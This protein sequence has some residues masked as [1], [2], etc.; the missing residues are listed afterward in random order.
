[1]LSRSPAR[2]RS[3][4]MVRKVIQRELLA[5]TA[6]SPRMS[7][8][9]AAD[10]LDRGLVGL[11]GP[12]RSVVQL[13]E[14][15]CAPD[16]LVHLEDE[17]AAGGVERVAVDL[18]DAPLRLEDVEG[19]GVEDEVGREPHVLAVALVDRG[20]E[21]VGVTGADG[22]VEAVRREDEVVR[23]GELVHVRG[24]GA[25]V[26]GH[27]ELRGAGLEQLEQALARHGREPMAAARDR[28]APEV[29]VDV[30]PSSE[31]RLHGS[32][33]RAVGVLDAAERLVREDDPEAE[34]VVGG[35]P[36]PDG[37]LVGRVE[38]LGERREVQAPGPTAD[39]GDPHA[40]PPF[41]GTP[42]S[43]CPVRRARCSAVHGFEPSPS[44]SA[45]TTTHVP[46]A[47]VRSPRVI[48]KP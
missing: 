11:A 46:L 12:P 30:V 19:E 1:M 42:L 33:D 26:D 37:D 10:P 39:D 3:L 14:S 13:R 41:P 2:H 6:W 45:W 18:H 44:G 5:K 31:L 4:R 24:V 38:L 28:P 32:V 40:L 21:G 16:V 48:S 36:L 47:M 29:D 27:A 8:T 15:G 17:G 9:D 43:G 7:A 34:R 23:R 22:R 35:V 20:L 25:E